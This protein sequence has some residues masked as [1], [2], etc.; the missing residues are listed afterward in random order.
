MNLLEEYVGWHNSCRS[1]THPHHS[2]HESIVNFTLNVCKRA[3]I[4]GWFVVNR[5]SSLLITIC[6]EFMHTESA[7]EMCTREQEHVL[8]E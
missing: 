2:L 6:V 4:F 3:D 5:K 7:D 8:L 1:R